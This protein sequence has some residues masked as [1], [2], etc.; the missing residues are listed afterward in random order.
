ML[1]LATALAACDRE[2]RPAAGAAARPDSASGEV[3][4]YA[5]M[6][7]SIGWLTDS[8]IVAL[9][10]QLNADVQEIPRLE[11]Q[12]W[13][14]EPMRYLAGEL[15]R[16]HA[17]LQYSID[18]IATAKRIPAQMPAV[19]PQLKAPYD[20]LLNSQ[21]GLPIAEREAQ[22]LHMV[23]R[24][25][26]R[27]MV[28]FGALGGNATDPDLKALLVNRA[29]LMEQ[30]HASRIQLITGA[31]AKADSTR[32]DSARERGRGRGGRR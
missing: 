32:A 19:A 7:N 18:S 28:D 22:F 13:A 29:V 21:I 2:D 17:R 9:A 30:A 8:N 1:A 3:A 20:S 12:M 14:Q 27:S 4:Q 23:A 10:G 5:L 31:V 25:H 15:I 16:D 24:A 26:A 6:K 11:T